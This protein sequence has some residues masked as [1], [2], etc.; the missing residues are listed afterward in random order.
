MSAVAAVAAAR[1]VQLEVRTRSQA[2]MA[3]EQ[4]RREHELRYDRTHVEGTL[5]KALERE[6]Q[7]ELHAC[8]QAEREQELRNRKTAVDAE[9][10]A[11]LDRERRLQ[12][13]TDR[14]RCGEV[15]LER[16]LDELS[17][18]GCAEGY[19][20]QPEIAPGKRPDAVVLLAS[21]QRLVVDSKAPRP[22]HELLE[23][24]CEEKRREYVAQLKR[25]ITEL[26]SRRYHA[27]IDAT[28][29]RRPAC[30]QSISRTWLLLPGEGY[31][32]A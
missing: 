15:A 3:A 7:L 21:G 1:A 20:L 24:A 4:A 10:R 5:R 18:L 2:V 9:L 17:A 31:L 25:H 12:S 19:E 30:R 11:A 8:A 23:A 29:H 22:P 14:G 6:R 32:H 13:I 27:A 26:G 16:L 28:P